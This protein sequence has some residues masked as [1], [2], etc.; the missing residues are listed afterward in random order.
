MAQYP[1]QTFD[2]RCKT[3]LATAMRFHDSQNTS[4]RPMVRAMASSLIEQYETFVPQYR[5]DFRETNCRWRTPHPGNKLL[6]LGQCSFSA[7]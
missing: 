1:Y 7:I 3:G 6:T 5:I 2:I 4:I